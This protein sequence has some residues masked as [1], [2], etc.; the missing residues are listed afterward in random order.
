MR[1]AQVVAFTLTLFGLLLALTG[2]TGG[3]PVTYQM[4]TVHTDCAQR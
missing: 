4:H 3:L 2:G 1:M